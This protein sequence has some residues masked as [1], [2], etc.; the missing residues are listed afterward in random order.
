MA[1]DYEYMALFL[2]NLSGLPVRVYRDG[3]CTT[4]PLLS[5]TLLSWRRKLS[6]GQYQLLHDGQFPLL[7]AVPCAK[8]WGHPCHRPSAAYSG[9]PAGRPADIALHWGASEPL[10]RVFELP[11]CPAGL[12]PAQLFAGSLHHQLLYNRRKGKRER[13]AYVGRAGRNTGGA[14]TGP[15]TV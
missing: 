8:G 2:T 4:T 13:P 11:L 1:I 5:L 15:R 14:D 7:R 12:S 3:Q 9:G 6:Y 10:R